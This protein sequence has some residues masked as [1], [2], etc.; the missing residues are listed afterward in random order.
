MTTKNTAATR[1]NEQRSPVGGSG[2][3]GLRRPLTR[4]PVSHASHA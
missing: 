4:L 3:G 1:A 2:A